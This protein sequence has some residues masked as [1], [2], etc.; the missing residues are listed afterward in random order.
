MTLI[1]DLGK[2]IAFLFLLL[3]IFLITAKSKRKL[4]NYLFASFLLVS[5]IDL[6]GLFWSTSNTFFRNFKS[7]S[8]LLQMPLYYLYVKSACYYNFN[9]RKKHLLHGILFLF[10]F[11][12]FITTDISKQGY[13]LFDVLLTVQY[14]YYIVAVFLVL[15]TF[16]K[17]YR[18]NYSSNHHRIYQWLLR[19]TILFLI[20][21]FFVLLRGF[22]KNNDI[23]LYLYMCTGFF[24]LFMI[25]WFVL[26]CLYRPE[27]FAGIDKDLVPVKIPSDFKREP[28]QLKQLLT[29]METEKPYLDDTLTLQK[30]AEKINMPEKQLSLLINQS[31]GKHFF[32]FV[33]EFRINNAKALLKEQPQL[34]VLEILYQVG[35]NS[36]SSFY[37]AF[38]KETGVT[39]TDYRKSIG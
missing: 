31:A 15:R 11:V 16:K 10:F 24:A 38:K 18:E 8:V 39:P 14:Y 3:V 19:T 32:D 28:E 12:L 23:L 13:Q 17:L 1:S 6:S 33:N 35:F 36:K 30:L 21:N 22:I 27:L 9:L 20:G 25:S 2:I 7:A 26:N 29:L 37:T 5:A 4:P 34:T